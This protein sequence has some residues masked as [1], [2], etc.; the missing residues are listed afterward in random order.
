MPGSVFAPRPEGSEDARPMSEPGTVELAR[1]QKIFTASVRALRTGPIILVV[2]LVLAIVDIGGGDVTILA[3]ATL[4]LCFIAT[5][6]G[7]A[8]LFGL[9]L[10]HETPGVP[11]SPPWCV[12]CGIISIVGSFGVGLFGLIT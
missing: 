6:F 7:L 11:P 10:A 12:P 9:A 8:G 1:A 3:A 2:A 5:A 4:L